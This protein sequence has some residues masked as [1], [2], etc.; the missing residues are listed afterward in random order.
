MM[1]KAVSEIFDSHNYTK[2]HK[3]KKDKLDMWG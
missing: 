2:Q 1:Y 3:N